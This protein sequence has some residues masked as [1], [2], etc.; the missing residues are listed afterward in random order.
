MARVII[1]GGTSGIGLTT[2]KLL[3]Q[4]KIEV[5]ILGR[6][7]EKLNQTLTEIGQT[8]KGK[9]VDAT[10]LETLKQAFADIGQ[11]DHLVIAL[12]GGKGIGLFHELDLDDLRK[13]FEGK[14]FP[15]LQTAQAVLP[16]I[17]PNG[18]ITFITSISSQSKAIGTAGLGA[19]NGALEIMIPTLAKELKP[20]RINA[21]APGVVNTTW[22]DFL[23][24]E[25]KQETFE[26]YAK[27]IPLGRIAEPEDIA[28]MIVAF[29]ENNYVTGQVIAVDGGLSLGQ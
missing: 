14:F 5:I 6:N 17:S 23:P 3:A 10:N 28:H 25:K 15:Q 29:I 24:Q 22:W 12:S 16:Y 11:I 18:S 20:I 13:G 21:V 7:Q 8:A 19:I 1:A 26:Q 4:K 2:A 27:T 9:I